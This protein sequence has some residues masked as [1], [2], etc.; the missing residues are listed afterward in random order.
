[1]DKKEKILIWA[2]TLGGIFSLVMA[3][4]VGI[5][6]FGVT[7]RTLTGAAIVTICSALVMREI[8]KSINDPDDESVFSW[9]R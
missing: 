2:F 3:A 9:D 6:T 8:H 4:G 5:A 7:W 1:M